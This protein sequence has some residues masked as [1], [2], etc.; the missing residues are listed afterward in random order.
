MRNIFYIVLS[1]LIIMGSLYSLASWYFASLIIS[2]DNVGCTKDH[3]VYCGDPKE[4]GIPAEDISFPS[5]E[6]TLKGWYIPSVSQSRNTIIFVHGHGASRFEAARW[7]RSLRES[8]YNILAFDLRNH[9]D[10]SKSQTTMGI[11]EAKDISSA[12]DYLESRFGSVNVG[13][14][15]VSMGASSSIIA[16]AQDSRIRVGVF[17]SGYSSLETQL[18][19]HFEQQYEGLPKQLVS[20]TFKIFQART[21]LSVKRIRPEEAISTIKNRPVFILHC[22]GDMEVKIKHGK[23][24]F[25]AANEPKRFWSTPCTIHGEFWQYNPPLVEAEVSKFFKANL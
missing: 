14:F 24:L 11:N 10:S 6:L 3:F 13:I 12:I 8:G 17:E 2:P 19:D 18:H 7:F 21:G 1:I 5:E 25:K 20:L 23:Q 16:M 22:E 15:G 9:G 4:R